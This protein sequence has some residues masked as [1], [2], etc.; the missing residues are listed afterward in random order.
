MLPVTVGGMN[1]Q[2]VRAVLAGLTVITGVLTLSVTLVWNVLWLGLCRC[3]C[4]P[5]L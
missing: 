5:S 3:D 4:V 1:D 2:Q